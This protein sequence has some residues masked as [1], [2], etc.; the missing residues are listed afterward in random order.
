M[1][2]RPN[3][4]HYL[5]RFGHH[6]YYAVNTPPGD[7]LQAMEPHRPSRGVDVA[8]V[9]RPDAQAGL[10]RRLTTASPACDTAHYSRP[11]VVQ[12]ATRV[13]AEGRYVDG[14]LSEDVGPVVRR[15]DKTDLN[16][17]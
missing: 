3:R 2:R 15:R 16:F 17:A 4:A 1:G 11:R 8:A 6:I 7:M 5:G 14:G 9:P 12:D 13:L 10:W